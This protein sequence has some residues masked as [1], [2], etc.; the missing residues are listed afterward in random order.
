MS[1]SSPKRGNRFRTAFFRGSPRVLPDVTNFAGG[2]EF[3]LRLTSHFT[4]VTYQYHLHRVDA[5]GSLWQP[6]ERRTAQSGFFYS[7][8]VRTGRGSRRWPKGETLSELA[9]DIQRFIAENISSVVQIE[10]LLLLKAHPQ[11]SWTADEVARALYA[12]ATLL[13]DELAAWRSRGLLEAAPDR[14]D[15][16]RFAPQTPHLATVVETLEEAYKNR[17]VSVI[18]AIYSKPVDKIRTFA[19]AFRIRKEQ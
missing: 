13:A 10:V 3:V 4:V 16:Y 19:D 5:V 7:I 1:T 2:A 17:R 6:D 11:Q 8:S 18:T 14:P 12:G 15:A 9:D